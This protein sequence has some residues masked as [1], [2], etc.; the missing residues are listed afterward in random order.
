MK[1]VSVGI[2]FGTTNTAVTAIINGEPV[3]LGEDGEYPFV[4][5]VAIP[6]NSDKNFLFGREVKERRNELSQEY[7]V[8]TSVKSYLGTDT[9]FTAMG[10][11]YTPTDITAL[12]LKYVKEK[13]KNTFNLEIVSATFSFP[14]DFSP[15]ARGELLKS[16]NRVGID[17]KNFINEA[18][19]GYISM[20]PSAKSLSSVMV[21]D[22][23]GGTLDISILDTTQ[24]TVFESAIYGEKVG[25]DDIDLLIA[26]AIHNRLVK[27]YGLNKSF[28]EVSSKDKDSLLSRSEQ[29]KIN[30]SENSS[31]SIRMFKYDTIE[32]FEEELDYQEFESIVL[33][34]IK[35]K[36]LGSIDKAMKLAK[37]SIANIDAVI[38]VGGS[39]N[40]KPFENAMERLFGLDKILISDKPQW[41]VS[42]G[43]ASLNN[44]NI[45]H[46]LSDSVNILM[47]DDTTYSILPSGA[48]VGYQSPEY[49]FYLVEDSPT[50]NFIF[51]NAQN[52]YTYAT[53]QVKTKGF[54]EEKL[55]LSAKINTNQVGVVT[56]CNSSMSHGYKE[57][58]EINSLRF[59][60]NFAS[61]GSD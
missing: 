19:A 10:K 46:I 18:T 51:T 26:Q 7:L 30:F 4:S 34:I 40:L 21:V 60:Y 29:L 44:M 22:W 28:D 47:S 57:I 33:P 15:K 5:A 35:H 11:S 38:I 23:G 37:K 1:S 42:K 58:V 54:L 16:A 17:V 13:I 45:Q 3:N 53:K 32:R 55:V 12:F 52:D 39:S 56:I 6:K 31:G 20:R 27:K 14:V 24:N 43:S 61:L 48:T 36:V 25:G 8:V 41:E 2:D 59:K 9:V 49:T 50:A